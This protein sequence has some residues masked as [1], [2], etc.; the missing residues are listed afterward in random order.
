MEQQEIISIAFKMT[1]ALGVVLLVFGGTIFFVKK[2][3]GSTTGFFKKGVK[4]SAKP[5]EVLA[6]QSLGP[7]RGI[8]LLRCLDKKIL[9]GSTNASIQHLS[10]ISE[11]DEDLESEDTQLNRNFQSSLKASTNGTFDKG[12]KEIARV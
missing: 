8:Y 9:V 2:F 10:D 6:F 3:S 5:L 12:L 7:G 11:E 4:S 1:V